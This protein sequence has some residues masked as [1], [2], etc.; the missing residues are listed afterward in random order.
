M[1][2]RLA[3]ASIRY[4]QTASYI[5]IRFL[6]DNTY[7]LVSRGLMYTFPRPHIKRKFHLVRFGSYIWSEPDLDFLARETAKISLGG[8]NFRY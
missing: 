5:Y 7:K 2:A 8:R 4:I 1:T 6:R 3:I